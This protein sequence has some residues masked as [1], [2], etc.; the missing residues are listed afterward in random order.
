MDNFLARIANCANTT[1]TP[2]VI[3]QGTP[4][5]GKTTLAQ[6]LAARHPNAV[7][8][9]ADDFFLNETGDYKFDAARLTDA[10]RDCKRKAEVAISEGKAVIVDNC[11]ANYSDAQH[12]FTLSSKKPCVAFLKCMS[13]EHSVNVSK[14]SPHG[15]PE[16]AVKRCFDKLET[17]PGNYIT[18]VVEALL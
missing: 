4:G 15:V 12:Y 1:Q 3:I 13:R 14:R 6:K 16:H 8:V 7:V 9:S 17:L 5:T 11:N 18:H 2:I 10:H